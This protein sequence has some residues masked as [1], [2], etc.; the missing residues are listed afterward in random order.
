MKVLVAEDEENIAKLH[1]ISFE[2]AG[3]DVWITHDGVE[4]INT[5]KEELEKQ[6]KSAKVSEETFSLPGLTPFDVIILD[7]RMPKKDGMQVAREILD[8]VP[9]QRIIFVS[10]Y[11]AE[12][13]QEAV[14]TLSRVVELVQ[15]PYDMDELVSLAEDT[16]IWNELKEMNVNVA[17]LRSMPLNH[18]T[19]LQLLEG[20][21]KLQKGRGFGTQ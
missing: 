15:K 16:A 4:C 6:K 14:K 21:R 5:F 2:E 13:L 20:L 8:L 17:E 9:Q 19:V 12:T 3:H 1:R 11:V 10:A 7:Y 18:S